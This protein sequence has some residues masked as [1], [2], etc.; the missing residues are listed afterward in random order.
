MGNALEKVID[1]IFSFFPGVKGLYGL[2]KQVFNLV[3][4][5]KE[6]KEREFKVVFVEYPHREEWALAFL[7][8]KCN[9]STSPS[10]DKDYYTVFMPTTPNPTTGFLMFVPEN[11]IIRTDL[12][13]NDAI[14]L[15]FTGGIIKQ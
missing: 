5:R 3:F 2:L 13:M 9:E 8:G 7:T 10:D 11:K 4:R 6:E 14:K 1:K 12:T 15:I